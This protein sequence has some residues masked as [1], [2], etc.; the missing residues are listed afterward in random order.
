MI[1]KMTPEDIETVVQLEEEVFGHSLGYDMIYN[2]ITNH[3][4]AHYFVDEEHDE[5]IGYVGLWINDNIGQIV[6]FLVKPTHQ[7]KG[8]GKKWITF[9]MDYFK[10]NNV[11]IVSLEVRETNERAIH[12][13]ESYGFKKSYKRL[14]YYDNKEDA[15]VLIWRNNDADISR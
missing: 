2:E 13:Y 5:I 9:I 14:K 6:N 7:N 12:L 10:Q 4:F 11:D 1:R 15:H 3:G 8:L